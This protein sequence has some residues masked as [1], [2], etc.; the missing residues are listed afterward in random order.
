LVPG[1]VR[2]RWLFVLL[3]CL[4]AALTPLRL[5]AQ[6]AAPVFDATALREP[7]PAITWLTQ[8]GDDPDGS[9]GWAS[10]SFDDS[11]WL[12]FN[13]ETGS[14]HTLFPNARP[15]FIWYRLHMKVTPGQQ[16]L[17]FLQN[18]IGSAFQLFANGEPVMRV[19]RIEPYRPAYFLAWTVGRIP[20]E[21]TASGSVVLA[22][23]MRL[24]ESEWANAYPGFFYNNLLFGQVSVLETEAWFD[25]IRDSLL[26]GLDLL[27]G[28]ALLIGALLLYSAQREPAYL[29]L[30]L[31]SL[32]RF[33]PTPLFL[34][35]TRWPFPYDWFYYLVPALLFMPYL[36]ARTYLAFVRRPLGWRMN[37]YLAVAGIALTGDVL[38]NPDYYSV[39]LEI[40][41]HTPM[42]LLESVILP[43]ILIR[44]M[45]R[46]DRDAGILLVP[47]WLHGL[48]YYVRYGAYLA[49][50]IPAIRVPA[51]QVAQAVVRFEAG[52]FTVFPEIVLSILASLSLALIILL[53]SNRQSRQQAVLEGEL[54]NARVVQ[55][56]I[57]PEAAVSVPGFRVESVYE[58]ARQVGGDFFQVLPDGEGGLLVVVGD[59]AGK[60]LPAAML[61]SVL[62]GA[63]RTA[64]AY[65]HDPAEVLAQL[66][67]RLLG[68]TNGGF[69]TAIAAH[70][71]ANGTVRIANA[72]HLPP[73]LDG[74]E[75]ELPGALP[76]G[77]VADATY[78]THEF[79]LKAG[80]RLVF[81]SDGV[82]EAQNAQG[83]LLGF[84]RAA[85]LSTEPVQKISQAAKAFGQE[86]DITVV[87]IAREAAA[88]AAA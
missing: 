31:L 62:V 43:A 50:Q 40:L 59:V 35:G 21:V 81:Y 67:E 9:L 42:I 71:A 73:Y 70:I 87:A 38:I 29:W 26:R 83:D 85:E 4:A 30:A 55:Q 60:G 58:P 46:G 52:P 86:D 39:P 2:F 18:S 33:A 28:M 80:S 17:G 41:I 10:P 61:V 51:F 5:H 1:A 34:L 14:L 49:A 69:S 16:E 27:I 47:L 3:A 11:H 74:R 23:R 45:R 53:R 88:E 76:L 54:E 57:L 20:A 68:R 65:T 78:Q 22:I 15:K 7:T 56:M 64:A 77:V 44:Q 79:A 36:L 37:L 32:A 24:S 82:V 13:T 75:I 84:E 19:G 63:V 8:V 25:A 48:Y 66:N 72:G 6:T 12:P